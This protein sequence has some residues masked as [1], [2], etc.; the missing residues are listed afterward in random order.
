MYQHDLIKYA[1]G[2]Y[3]RKIYPKATE[4]QIND[5][6]KYSEK[7]DQPKPKVEMFYYGL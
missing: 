6:M 2:E 3:L 4:Q 7:G 1:R 5:F